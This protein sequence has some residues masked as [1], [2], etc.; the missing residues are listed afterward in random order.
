MESSISDATLEVVDCSPVAFDGAKLDEAHAA[1][2]S[3]D[4]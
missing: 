3:E 4:K 1:K 2:A